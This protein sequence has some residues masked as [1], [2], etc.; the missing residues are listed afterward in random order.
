[1][2]RSEESKYKVKQVRALLEKTGHAG[3]IIKKQPNF[4]WIS[5]GGRG[6]IGLA[7]E[8]AC[9]SIVVTKDGV[10]VAGNNIEL[11]R[12]A[13]EEF[14]E[15]FAD[16]ISLPW[17]EDGTIDAL[18]KKRFGKLTNDA[19]QDAWFRK[20]R[21]KLLECEEARYAKL[22]KISAQALEDV[23]ASIKPG[24]SEFEIS[25]RISEL[26]WAAGIEP[27][28]VLIAADERSSLLRHYVPTSKKAKKGVICSICA[29][30]GGLVVSATR[31]ASFSKNFAPG[32]K[33][34]LKVEQAAFEATKPGVEM[35]NI[36]KK[37]LDAYTQNG[38]SGEW[39]NHHQG[40]LTG[41]QAR[42]IRVL[43]DTKEK[44]S[45]HQ[46]FAW[47]PSV[48]GAKC[49]DTIL[50]GE[51]SRLSILTKTGKNWPI[52]KYGQYLRPDILL[53]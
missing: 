19:E 44:V 10:F 39:N 18:L 15:G 49:E 38:F 51:N 5:S 22:G 41:Y 33:N 29:R 17:Q 40:G 53:L 30:A 7:S 34:L 28:T 21:V 27:I 32:Y 50:V 26:Y 37:L 14:P 52:I 23:C 8:G 42:E 47:N 9:A 46:A 12:L 43:S 16:P 3:I 45:A 2:N 4:S 25:G 20:T 1:M 11:P 13:A 48:I 24:I 6:F 35:G 31:L 36:Y